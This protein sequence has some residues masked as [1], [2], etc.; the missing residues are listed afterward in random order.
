M[1]GK[2]RRGLPARLDAG[3]GAESI[4]VD[5]VRGPDALASGEILDV[6]PVGVAPPEHSVSNAGAGNPGVAHSGT[7][8][9]GPRAESEICGTSAEPAVKRAVVGELVAVTPKSASDATLAAAMT[10]R[11]LAHIRATTEAALAAAEKADARRVLSQ[12]S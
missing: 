4:K 9:P 11:M 3:G 2:S 1:L 10:D 12:R 6:M 8:C 5:A 7:D